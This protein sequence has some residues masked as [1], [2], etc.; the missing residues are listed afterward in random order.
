MRAILES[1]LSSVRV[2]VIVVDRNLHVQA[3][4]HKSEDLRGL[5]TAEVQG[6]NFLNLDTG[7]PVDHLKQAVRDCLSGD[8]AFREVV[9]LE[10]INR[11][12]KQIECRITCTPLVCSSDGIRGATLLVEEKDPHG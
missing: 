6:Q 2:F 12:G 3:W 11:R 10:A 9:R 4:N 1:V 7:L 5:R 8:Q